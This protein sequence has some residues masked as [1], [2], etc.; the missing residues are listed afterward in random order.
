MT[1]AFACA[2]LIVLTTGMALCQSFEVASVKPS[3]PMARGSEMGLAPGGLFTARNMTLKLLIRQAYNVRD[4]QISGGPGWLDTERYDIV[5]KGDGPALSEDE[6]SKLPEAQRNKLLEEFLM[7][8]RTL[9]VDRFQL[10]VHRETKELPV[11][12]LIVARG[13]PKIHPAAE[14]SSAGGQMSIRRAGAGSEIIGNKVPLADLIQLLSDQVGRTVLDKTGLKGN[15]D[16]KMSFAPDRGPGQQP[17]G[18]GDDRQL[19]EPDG[20]SIFTALQEQLG[21][22]LDPQKGPVEVIVI[23]SAQKAS[24]N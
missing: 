14:D 22:K 15:Y 2:N 17:R 4:F 16:L 3:D 6:M 1:R 7:K 5:A 20:P 24:A 21:L 23:D 11:Y 12:A 10:K 8:L 13:G 9:L 18:P 19:P